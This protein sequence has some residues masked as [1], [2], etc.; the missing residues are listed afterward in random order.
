M[1]DDKD[2]QNESVPELQNVNLV[3]SQPSLIPISYSDNVADR[4]DNKTVAKKYMN[5]F[6]FSKL[7]SQFKK[8]NLSLGITSA[9]KKDGKTLV[10]SNMAVSL[11]KGYKCKTL[12]ID[13]N[14]QNP[15]LHKVFGTSQEQGLAEALMFE[16]IRVVPTL[17]DDLF[18]M[19]AGDCE[20]FNPDVDNTLVL[21]NILSSFKKEFDFVIIDMCPIL[22]IKNFPIHYINE[23]D[24]LVSVIDAERTK[25]AEF[26]KIFRHLDENRF[27][28]YVFNKV[29]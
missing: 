8:L 25:K 6:N 21:R 14:F 13:M 18:L 4:L 26:A 24:G 15:Q 11:A 12:L 27:I 1:E 16:M 17:V 29:D 5:S 22:P 7:S 20:T 10:A 23:I 2:T 19:T 28:G 9:N 3:E